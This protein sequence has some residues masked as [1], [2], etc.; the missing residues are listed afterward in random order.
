MGKF[1]EVSCQGD[2]HNIISTA[3]RHCF[4]SY[5]D[6]FA[7]R[8]D[9]HNERHDEIRAEAELLRARASDATADYGDETENAGRN[10]GNEEMLGRNA[11]GRRETQIRVAI[12]GR[13][14]NML[15]SR[16]FP[17]PSPF[18]RFSIL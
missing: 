3:M 7:Q 1:A 10:D 15:V 8:Y 4:L 11:A 6:H 9:E 12:N 18:G 17:D 16:A 2:T 13:S 14:F 5:R